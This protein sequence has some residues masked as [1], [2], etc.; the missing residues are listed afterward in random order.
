MK[1]IL[2]N[3]I[4]LLMIGWSILFMT[5]STGFSQNISI[6]TQ[7][8]KVGETVTFTIWIDRA[9]NAVDAFGFDLLY[10]SAVLRYTG[11]FF[12]EELSRTFEFFDANEPQTGRIR[13][14]GFTAGTP[15][16]AQHS[17][18]LVT[19]E[20]SVIGSGNANVSLA[21][22]VDDLT[23]WSTQTAVFQG[24]SSP[25]SGS[26]KEDVAAHPLNASTDD[27][28][29]RASAL[30]GSKS[31]QS[32]SI[33][34]GIGVPVASGVRKDKDSPQLSNTSTV[35]SATSLAQSDP[36]PHFPRTRPPYI[37]AH[38]GVRQNPLMRS[39]SPS[40]TSIAPV[41]N[42]PQKPVAAKVTV[43]RT[44]IRGQSATQ[45]PPPIQSQK[46]V[47]APPPIQV[48]ST[49]AV[50]NRTAS[51][52]FGSLNALFSGAA[53]LGVIGMLL[54]QR[55]Q[56]HIQREEL[57]LMKNELKHTV[58][59]N[60]KTEKAFREQTYLL[61]VAT[62]L[63]SLSTLAKLTEHRMNVDEIKMGPLF[64]L[65]PELAAVYEEK[66]DQYVCEIEH[67]LKKV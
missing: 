18:R 10:D 57:K 50:P 54:L 34:T 41:S 56:L 14:G 26:S 43:G 22:L 16:D 66:L 38:K 39:K 30:T 7:G 29:F 55:K 1:R 31:P 44:A 42:S 19:L 63:N 28:P 33:T 24:V 27:T 32:D 3:V 36:E 47:Q 12:P 9:P 20:F 13:I 51:D 61:L 5:V 4:G 2:N 49:T 46:S 11:T 15:V 48:M 62:K 25:S 21:N 37:S 40:K 64:H 59:A 52:T 53:F 17:G 23:A 58:N 67:A 65:K 35:E 60:N 6:D 8:G 45:A